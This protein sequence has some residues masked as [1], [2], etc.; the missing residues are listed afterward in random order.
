MTAANKPEP[1]KALAHNHQMSTRMEQVT[2]LRRQR[3][4]YSQIGK[5]LGITRQAA[6]EIHQ[7]ALKRLAETATPDELAR[8]EEI[9]FLEG[10]IGQYM[11]VYEQTKASKPR[12]AIEALNGMHRYVDSLHKLK[13][14][15]PPL[16]IEHRVISISDLEAELLKIQAELDGLDGLD[17]EDAEI[18]GLLG[19]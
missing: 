1:G 6:W 2:A 12:T 8:L 9:E 15:H 11:A 18:V 19:S 16:Q 5:A 7:A 4:S 10:V 3:Y 13:G 14:V 17:I